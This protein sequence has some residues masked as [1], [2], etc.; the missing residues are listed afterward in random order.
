[1]RSEDGHGRVA[2]LVPPV[3]PSVEEQKPVLYTDKGEPIYRKV[4]FQA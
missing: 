1:M 3:T 4:G 2:P